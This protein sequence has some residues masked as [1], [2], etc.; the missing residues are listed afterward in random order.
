MKK[1]VLSH[2]VIQSI[3]WIS[4]KYQYLLIFLVQNLK[5]FL[6]L[7]MKLLKDPWVQFEPR[8]YDLAQPGQP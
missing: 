8:A 4:V 6:N 3:F 1:F 2:S 5:T 7:S